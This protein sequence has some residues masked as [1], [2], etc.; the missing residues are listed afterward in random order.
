MSKFVKERPKFPNRAIITAGM[1]Y[2]NKELHFG[3]VGGMFVHADTFA[4]FMRDR[5]GS[6]NVIF[7]SGTDCYGSPALEGYRKEV[8]KGLTGTIQDYVG[9][10]HISQKETL[11]NFEIELNLFAASGLD[12]AC[13]MHKLVSKE[14]FEKLYANGSLVKD[15]TPQ[16]FDE[17]LGVFLN[18]RQV[19]GKCPVEGCSSEHGYADE[20]SLGHQYEPSELIDP[21]S[22][23]SGKTPV[24]KEVTNWYFKLDSY[25]DVMTEVLNDWKRNTNIRK[26]IVKAIDEFLKKPVIYVQKNAVVDLEELQGAMP[27]H[28]LVNEEKKPSY[29]F[30]FDCLSDRDKARECLNTRNIRFRTG[31][32]LVPFRLSGNCEWGV[33]VPSLEGLDDLTFWVWPESLWAPVSFSRTYLKSKGADDNEWKN[34]WMSDDSKVYQFIGEDNIYFYGIA[35]MGMFLSYYCE[36]KEDAYKWEGVNLPHIIANKHILFMNK[37]ASSSSE[38]KPPM[39]AELLDYY[40]AEQLRIHFLS[41]GL[42]NKNA[43]FQPNIYLPENERESKDPVLKEGNL[44]T[45]V[46]NRLARSCF[47]TTQTYFDGVL[48]KGEVSA[49]VIDESKRQ[50]LEFERH[51]YN[52]DFHRLTYVLDEY[53]RF[54]NKLWVANIKKAEQTEDDELRKQTLIDCFHGLRTALTLLHPIA[55]NGCEMLREYL[56]VDERIWNWEYIFEDLYFFCDENHQLKFLEPRVDFFSK[57]PSQFITE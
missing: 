29:T 16:F 9:K 17:D 55:P 15:S 34:W 22:T 36:N 52:H 1:P 27:S 43:S 3:H 57:H 18:G 49:R 4:R 6:E 47:Y 14:L 7:V 42:S 50:T 10:N 25:T 20:C 35:E 11:K 28:E 19:M 45:N 32:T 21:I 5:I 31:K 23:L 12:E 39:A 54:M 24:L 53:I 26:Y 37:K 33:P 46:F 56:G 30:I 13:E 44:L 2:G 40:T 8:E 48:P 41:L 51:M 38:I